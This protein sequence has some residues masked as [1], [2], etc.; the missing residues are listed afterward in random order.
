MN[1]NRNHALGFVAVVST[2]ALLSGC[3]ITRELR[4]I[5]GAV[6]SSTLGEIHRIAASAEG[7]QLLIAAHTGVWTTTFDGTSW[8]APQPSGSTEDLSELAVLSDG[9]LVGIRHEDASQLLTSD[10]AARTWTTSQMPA[11]AAYSELT[12]GGGTLFASNAGKL[13]TSDDLG[14]TWTTLGE[15]EIGSMSASQTDGQLLWII[16]SDGLVESRDGGERFSDVPD[17]P[18]TTLVTSTADESH[19]GSIATTGGDRRIWTREGADEPWRA[20]GR[21]VGTARLLTYVPGD[22]PYLAI[23]DDRGLIV[24][25]DYGYSWTA[26]T[27]GTK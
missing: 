8:Q 10:D 14:E 2:L 6:P 13:Q 5:D 9:T 15:T 27:E 7:D 16:G 26:L 4:T 17:S 1:N 25:P 12:A 19:P 21:Y 11:G 23:V 18:Q 20:K 22:T 24:S 3:A